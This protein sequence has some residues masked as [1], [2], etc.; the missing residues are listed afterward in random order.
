MDRQRGAGHGRRTGDRGLS[1]RPRRTWREGG[2]LRHLGRGR[3]RLRLPLAEPAAG[4]GARCSGI[5][6]I[7]LP[8]RVGISS[9]WRDSRF[10][11]RTRAPLCLWRNPRA[12]RPDLLGQRACRREAFAGHAAGVAGLCRPPGARATTELGNGA[13]WDPER[14]ATIIFGAQTRLED[15]PR[16]QELALLERA[17][18]L[19]LEPARLTLRTCGPIS[20]AARE[21]VKV[22]GK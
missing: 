22:S 5:A 9:V 13:E 21:R 16:N 17:R 11:P 8:L 20:A 12:G 19:R 14:R 3:D 6:R 18:P 15:A 2:S 7:R 1:G 4:R 10:V